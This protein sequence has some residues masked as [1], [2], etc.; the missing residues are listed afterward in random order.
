M[1]IHSSFSNKINSSKLPEQYKIYPTN[2]ITA[3]IQPID[4][5]TSEEG[6]KDS[7]SERVFAKVR[8][9]VV[10]L[11]N[12]FKL[13]RTRA[14]ISLFFLRRAFP[15]TSLLPIPTPA[16]LR[17]AATLVHVLNRSVSF[18]PTTRGNALPAPCL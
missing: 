15:L 6:V 7:C 16:Y 12:P 3:R 13:S 10:F 5:M 11:P 14:T 4:T 2:T 8:A 17:H 1:N 18:L 9:T